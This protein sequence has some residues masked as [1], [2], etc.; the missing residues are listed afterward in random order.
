MAGPVVAAMESAGLG[1]AVSNRPPAYLEC[2]RFTD[3]EQE[4]E[5]ALDSGEW[6]TTPRQKRRGRPREA[7]RPL[8]RMYRGMLHE[9]QQIRKS[10][11]TVWQRPERSR[12]ST[13]AATADLDE[14]CGGLRY[15]SSLMRVQ[16]E[17]GELRIG[18]RHRAGWRDIG[19]RWI[20]FSSGHF[21]PHEIAQAILAVVYGIAP[22]P[23]RKIVLRE[24]RNSRF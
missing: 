8:G 7:N 10:R 11:K 16:W 21:T 19:L 2:V 17:Q 13:E 18:V 24:G 9:L 23:V 1:A 3:G 4:W 15:V 14:I 6:S 12:A 20:D 5:F 22:D